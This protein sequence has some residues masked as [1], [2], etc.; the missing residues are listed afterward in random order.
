MQFRQHRLSHLRTAEAEADRLERAARE[1][2]PRSE[3][4][5][6]AKVMWARVHNL[7]AI[8]GEIAYT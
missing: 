8:C 1:K 5:L 2:F 4:S 7:C 6:F 3:K